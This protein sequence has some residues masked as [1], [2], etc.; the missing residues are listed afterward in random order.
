MWLQTGRLIKRNDP[1]LIRWLLTVRRGWRLACKRFVTIRGDIAGVQ[2]GGDDVSSYGDE[3]EIIVI[4][5]RCERV[6]S[7]RNH[8]ML[9]LPH[10]R[11]KTITVYGCERYDLE[12][13]NF[14]VQ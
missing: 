10:R 7:W 1:L 9:S 4:C 2:L 11:T 14:D 8:M 13:N 5:H 6:C 12:V 3:T